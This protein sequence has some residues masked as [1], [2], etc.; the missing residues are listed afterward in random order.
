MDKNN[1]NVIIEDENF[2]QEQKV[3]GKRELVL[4]Q[5]G[6]VMDCSNKE[7][8]SGWWLTRESQNMT[9]TNLRWISDTREEY[10][11]SVDTLHDILLPDF[12]KEMGEIANKIYKDLKGPG[13]KLTEEEKEELER[14][15]TKNS[16]QQHEKKVWNNKLEIY[17]GLQQ[18]I[19]FFLKR[20]GWYQNKETSE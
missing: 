10:I 16:P 14:Y 5:I 9:S 1:E 17:R 15:K 7:M 2:V 8:R 4:R 12:D 6:K 13:R 18:Q 11:R 19:F 20:I 3:L